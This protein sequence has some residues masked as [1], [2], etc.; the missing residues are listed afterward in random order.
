MILFQTP[1]APVHARRQD[2]ADRRIGQSG[3]HGDGHGVRDNKQPRTINRI[4]IP[5]S[6]VP[7][8]SPVEDPN[9]YGRTLKAFKE[10]YYQ[11]S[12]MRPPTG[13]NSMV[14]QRAPSLH[15]ALHQIAA[16][17]SYIDVLRVKDSLTREHLINKVSMILTGTKRV[18][19]IKRLP[20]PS[21]LDVRPRERSLST[22]HEKKN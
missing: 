8:R 20:T 1:P 7:D 4:Y 10:K 11:R 12:A 5:G 18:E 14:N 3:E 22:N 6:R 19:N 9:K 17:N 15:R 16:N 13:H 21:G 2:S